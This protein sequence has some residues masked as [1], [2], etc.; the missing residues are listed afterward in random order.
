MNHPSERIV[1]AVRRRISHAGKRLAFGLLIASLSAHALGGPSGRERFVRIVL[2]G[3]AAITAELAIT[4]EERARGLMFR[5]NIA[6]DQGML[7]V[8]EEPD[9]HGF[10]MKNTRI[11]LDM[12][13][14]DSDK[15]I[16][17]IE[18]DVPPCVAEPCPTY[19]T[20]IPARYVLELKGGSAEARGLKLYDRLEFILPFRLK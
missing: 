5:D 2:P 4:V 9:L 10:W 7:F 20:R 1:R 15:R 14:L 16:V 12:L 13:W 6:P 3:G 8:F 11:P 18:R 17:H 19:V